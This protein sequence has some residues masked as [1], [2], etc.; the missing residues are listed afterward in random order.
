MDTLCVCAGSSRRGLGSL[1]SPC[2]CQ[3]MHLMHL[4]AMPLLHAAAGGALMVTDPQPASRARPPVPTCSVAACSASTEARQSFQAT[5]VRM[6]HSRFSA[7]AAALSC[8]ASSSPAPCV[9]RRA[10]RTL[11]AGALAPGMLWGQQ[12][13]CQARR[14]AAPAAPGRRAGCAPPARPPWPRCRRA[15]RRR[16]PAA[17]PGCAPG[18]PPPA[19]S[20]TP[21]R[22]SPARA[23]GAAGCRRASGQQSH[24]WRVGQAWRAPAQHVRAL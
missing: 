23:A 2:A 4:R 19:A 10:S 21:A 12:Q 13:R 20:R 1:L 22:S 14:S 18:A 6:R 9:P 17:R 16:P 8:A 5:D 7:A 11:A 15:A 24:D 3:P